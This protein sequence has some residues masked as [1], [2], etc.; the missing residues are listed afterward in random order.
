[1]KNSLSYQAFLL[2]AAKAADAFTLLVLGMILARVLTLEDYGTYRQVWLLYYTLI[3]LF[4]LGIATSVNYFVP[5]FEPGQQKTFIFQTY[6]GLFILGFLFAVFLY[7]G[8]DFF[9]SRFNNPA[10]G[11]VIKIF[12]LVPLLTMPT[13]YYHNL[14]ICLKKAV[15]AAGILTSATLVRFGVIAVSISIQPSLKN[16]FTALLIYYVLE[17]IV[18]SLLI[19]RPFRT[20]PLDLK[21]QNILEQLKFTVPIGLSSVVGA[22]SRQI[23]KLIISGYFTSRE[24]AIY[25][26]GAMELPL[27][28]ILNAAVMSVL[29]PELVVLYNRGEYQKMLALWHRSIRKVSLIILPVMVFLFIFAREFLVLL[30]SE[31]YLESAGIFQIYLLTLPIRVTTFGSVL[32]AAGLSRVIMYYSVYT[33][34]IS[35]VLNIVMI[36]LWGV[37]GAALATVTAI[38]FMTFLQLGKICS[39]INCS[40]KDVYPWKVTMHI[41]A[42]SLAAGLV[43]L[44]GR[45]IIDNWFI[46][47]V[48]N[49]IVYLLIF[50]GLA[51]GTKLLS[52]GEIEQIKKKVRSRLGCL[53]KPGRK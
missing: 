26:N 11:Q 28:R 41:L 31:K 38:Y 22:F 39:V 14:Y 3:P 45:A 10:L 2:T 44:V 35:V 49:S 33:V 19:Y 37:W 18:L 34:I 16:I 12:S 21:K 25:A 47:L 29:M 8:A 7:T 40:F 46:S 36:R 43:P 32:L 24:Y 53:R 52:A 4:T 30:Y 51:A 50:A 9:G 17:F 42:V 6:S 48:V 1:M 5:R 20:V 23:D 27:A 13:S 15:V